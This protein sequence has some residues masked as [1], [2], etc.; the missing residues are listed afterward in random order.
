[1][2]YFTAV[3]PLPNTSQA[4]LQRGLMSSKLTPSVFSKL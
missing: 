4:A 1:M 3:R 2:W